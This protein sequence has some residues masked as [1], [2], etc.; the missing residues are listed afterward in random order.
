[1][2]SRICFSLIAEL[3]LVPLFLTFFL[4]MLVNIEI[5]I[6]A[7][8]AFSILILVYPMA[9]P[10]LKITYEKSIESMEEGDIA[11]SKAS[12]LTL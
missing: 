1:V 9:R 4:C 12:S 7:G 3:D 2:F 10:E 11:V 6:M 5:G 8:V